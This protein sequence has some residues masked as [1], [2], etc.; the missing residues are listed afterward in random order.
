[1]EELF[2]SATQ[3]YLEHQSDQFQFGWWERPFVTI[4]VV[5]DP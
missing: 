3:D 5:V 1:M 4:P 2:V